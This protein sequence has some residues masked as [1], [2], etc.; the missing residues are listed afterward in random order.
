MPQ[1]QSFVSDEETQPQTQKEDNP[2]PNNQA[3]DES[4]LLQGI[5][6]YFSDE[7]ILI[8]EQEKVRRN[9]IDCS[10]ALRIYSTYTQVAVSDRSLT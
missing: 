3:A 9:E 1:N 8:P 7:R 4:T 5:D 2:A 6:T 10:I